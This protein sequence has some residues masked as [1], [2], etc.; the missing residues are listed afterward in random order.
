MKAA[1]AII[2]PDLKSGYLHLSLANKID[3]IGGITGF[4]E[5]TV[6][7]DESNAY[8]YWHEHFNPNK[9]DCCNLRR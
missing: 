8:E 5:V 9:D 1:N 6:C 7:E 2:L 4:K 3:L